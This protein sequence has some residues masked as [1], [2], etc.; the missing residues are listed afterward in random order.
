MYVVSLAIYNLTAC[1]HTV[2]GD[3]THKKD[4]KKNE[5]N[6]SESWT[7]YLAPE[8]LDSPGLP[9]TARGDQHSSGLP[10]LSK[11]KKNRETTNM[12]FLRIQTVS[13]WC[14]VCTCL[15]LLF[16]ISLHAHTFFWEIR[17]REIS[18]VLMSPCC[19]REITNMRRR[20]YPCSPC[21]Q[22][23]YIEQD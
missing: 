16:I 6:C 23:D 5:N 14:Q 7:R 18:T 15:V 19:H 22:W 21:M 3:Q 2:W 17:H 4:N 13:P 9:M 8:P 12:I 20:G 1:S 10:V 11:Q